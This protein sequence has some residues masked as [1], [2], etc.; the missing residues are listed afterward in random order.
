MEIDEHLKY[1][2]YVI[3]AANHWTLTDRPAYNSTPVPAR[4]NPWSRDAH[5]IISCDLIAIDSFLSSHLWQVEVSGPFDR[6]P[7]YSQAVV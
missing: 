1:T 3:P 4:A 7:A 6:A 2:L 5:P